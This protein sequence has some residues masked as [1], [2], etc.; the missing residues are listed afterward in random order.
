MCAAEN[1]DEIVLFQDVSNHAV[2][3]DIR[4]CHPPIS[5]RFYSLVT[6]TVLV[7]EAALGQVQFSI[8]CNEIRVIVIGE[9]LIKSAKRENQATRKR[10]ILH[11]RIA[12]ESRC[13]RG[14]D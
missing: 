7:E 6:T 2:I 5:H 12:G 11:H 3:V 4:G 1:F 9:N 14:A 10:N 8:E 13:L